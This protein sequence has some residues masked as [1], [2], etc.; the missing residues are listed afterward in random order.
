MADYTREEL[1]TLASKL[2]IMRDE[3]RERWKNAMTEED[4]SYK[5]GITHG[6][7]VAIGQ[8]AVLIGSSK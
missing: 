4:L 5:Q 1:E 3:A 6:I 2:L 7:D 8:L